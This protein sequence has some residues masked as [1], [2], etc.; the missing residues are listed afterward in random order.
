M[1]V[2]KIAV[3]FIFKIKIECVLITYI[4]SRCVTIRTILCSYIIKYTV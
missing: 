2:E 3:T 4:C 1:V